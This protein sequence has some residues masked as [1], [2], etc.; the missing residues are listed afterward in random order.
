MKILVD[1][2]FTCFSKTKLNC[3][4]IRVGTKENPNQEDQSG[5]QM[6]NRGGQLIGAFYLLFLLTI[7]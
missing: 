3:C 1:R 2:V 7:I 6:L 4:L 5:S